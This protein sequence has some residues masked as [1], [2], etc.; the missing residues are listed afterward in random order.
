[1]F[2][3]SARLNVENTETTIKLNL[4]LTVGALALRRADDGFR[5]GCRVS[6]SSSL[7]EFDFIAAAPHHAL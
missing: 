7:L 5:I 3:L 6:Y 4:K 2:G 1:M